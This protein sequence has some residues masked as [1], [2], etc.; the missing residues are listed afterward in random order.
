MSF[1]EM[2]ATH[3]VLG[4]K[5]VDAFSLGMVLTMSQCCGVL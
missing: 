2:H 4:E 1:L 3:G 5:G